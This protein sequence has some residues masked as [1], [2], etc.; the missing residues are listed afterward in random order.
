MKG[1]LHIKG[2]FFEFSPRRKGTQ[3]NLSTTILPLFNFTP[4]LHNQRVYA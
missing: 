2:G 3:E 4:F 1:M